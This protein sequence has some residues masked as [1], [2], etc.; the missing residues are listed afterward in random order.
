MNKLLTLII[1]LLLSAG[2]LS[3]GSFSSGF[4]DESDALSAGYYHATNKAEAFHVRLA[5]H[6]GRGTER[7]H[8]AYNH[9]SVKTGTRLYLTPHSNGAMKIKRKG[10]SWYILPEHV[11]SEREYKLA[12]Q[13]AKTADELAIA[14]ATLELIEEDRLKGVP[15]KPI[16]RKGLV[17]TIR[18]A[19]TFNDAQHALDYSNTDPSFQKAFVKNLTARSA[20]CHWRVIYCSRTGKNEKFSRV[21][22]VFAPQGSTAAEYA[23]IVRVVTKGGAIVYLRKCDIEGV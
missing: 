8:V 18:E 12:L 1:T 22:G 15:R 23:G 9:R 7:E 21:A 14:K 16:P 20:A 10:R 17:V 3:A 4:E 6:T 11:V 2:S 13:A 19:Y 5:K